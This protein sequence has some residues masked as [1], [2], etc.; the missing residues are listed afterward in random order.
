[1]ETKIIKLE[2]FQNKGIFTGR[3]QG[4]EARKT[5]GLDNYDNEKD[6]AFQFAIPAN[7]TSFNPSFYLGLLYDSYEKLGLEGFEK[8]YSFKILVEDER[9]KKVINDDLLDG[10]RNAINSLS[11]K[12]GLDF[13][14]TKK[15]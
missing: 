12:S 15:R 11:G 4:E 5:I 8:R 7:T 14:L 1:M 3:P 6:V 13:L 2:Q 10:R 9:A